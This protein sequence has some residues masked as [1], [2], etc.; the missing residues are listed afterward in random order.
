MTPAQDPFYVVKEE[1]Q[2]SINKLQVTFQQWEQT[3]SNTER[4]Y[5]LQNSLLSAV[6]A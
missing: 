4:V 3:P 5:T 2:E 6:R 1:I